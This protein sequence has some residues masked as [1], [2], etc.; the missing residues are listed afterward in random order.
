MKIESVST[1]PIDPVR[2]ANVGVGSPAITR[3][4]SN[5]DT[6]VTQPRQSLQKD[7]P[8][9]EKIQ[10]DVEAINAQLESMN[11]SIQFSVD[12]GSKDMVIKIVDKNTG[13]VIRQIPSAEMLRLRENMTEMAGLIVKKTV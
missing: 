11:M 4:S 8:S 13:E 1:M 12:K 10:K 7:I 3:T 6:E 5:R 2:I 9:A